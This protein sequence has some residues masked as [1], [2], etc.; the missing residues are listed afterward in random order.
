MYHVVT[1]ASNSVSRSPQLRGGEPGQRGEAGQIR[2]ADAARHACVSP[3]RLK[4]GSC[5][6]GGDDWDSVASAHRSVGRRTPQ[7]RD[8]PAS[9]GKFVV[10]ARVIWMF[11]DRGS[12]STRFGESGYGG[13]EHSQQAE[14][15]LTHSA[16][17][18]THPGRQGRRRRP[19]SAWERRDPRRGEAEQ[20]YAACDRRPTTPVCQPRLR[21]RS[22]PGPCGRHRQG[23]EQP[24][25][26]GLFH[27]FDR[28]AKLIQVG[29][30]AG[31][32]LR[33]GN[34]GGL[35]GVVVSKERTPAC[36]PAGRPLGWDAVSDVPV[37]E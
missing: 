33:A 28:E 11:S 23:L 24:A 35:E 3:R 9:R 19:G 18:V 7:P 37:S 12:W 21:C 17:S 2:K 27:L 22:G 15:V 32:L 25:A 4:V 31:P 10:G 29:E 6:P 1:A 30:Q 13:A 36:V 20:T 34:S 5:W 14:C 8:R 26:A 16:F